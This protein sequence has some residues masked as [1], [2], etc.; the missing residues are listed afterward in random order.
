M[1]NIL[2]NKKIADNE[3]I[4]IELE[5]PLQLSDE[6]KKIL[7][8]FLT[9][10]FDT[11]EL[12]F[13]SKKEIVLRVFS[14]VIPAD[15]QIELDDNVKVNAHANTLNIKLSKNYT[16]NFRQQQGLTKGVLKP[17]FYVNSHDESK[18]ANCLE[19]SLLLY[20]LLIIA[21]LEDGLGFFIDQE[22]SHVNLQVALDSDCFILDCSADG[23]TMTKSLFKKTVESLDLF[24][25]W[26]TWH[27]KIIYFRRDKNYLPQAISYLK[28]A[29]QV[30]VAS[31]ITVE[32]LSNCYFLLGEKEKA[33]N[34]LRGALDK[35]PDNE[36]LKKVLRRYER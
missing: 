14:A 18:D 24:V 12:G 4:A 32:T 11:N 5:D 23:Y 20:H 33:L 26:N 1:L 7:A 9:Q 36:R 16:S 2:S 35:E 10:I 28:G 17:V 19:Y 13:L 29:N 30:A 25:Y 21:G 34:L 15:E 8:S 3:E 6:D 22:S 27:G 31:G